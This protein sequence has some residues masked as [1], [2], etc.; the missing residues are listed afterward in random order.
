MDEFRTLIDTP[1]QDLVRA[2]FADRLLARSVGIPPSIRGTFDYRLGVTPRAMG[3]A[4]SPF[5]DVDALL[6][7][8]Q[9][10]AK[11]SAVE[12]KRVKISPSTFQ[13]GQLNKLGG[14]SKAVRQ[15]NRLYRIGFAN[16]WLTVL[17]VADLRPI[18]GGV[19]FSFA[20]G[21]MLSRVRLT[22]PLSKLDEGI[23]VSVCEINQVSDQPANFRGT[24]GGELLRGVVTQVQPKPLTDA[25]VRFFSEPA[26][27]DCMSSDWRTRR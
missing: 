1:E 2:V 15:A 12:F 13:T 16:V 6:V 11:A 22:L 26:D 4:D 21:E 8:C 3:L 24:A 20:P 19:T 18:T 5:G 23:G 10:P 9:S 27:S 7:E 14:L 25:I 17:V